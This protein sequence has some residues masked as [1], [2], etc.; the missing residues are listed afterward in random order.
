MCHQ[1]FASRVFFEWI[2][3]IDVFD[4]SSNHCSSLISLELRDRFI[5]VPWRQRQYWSCSKNSYETQLNN[6]YVNLL[7]IWSSSFSSFIC[8]LF[9]SSKHFKCWW[10]RH[11]KTKFRV[12]RSSFAC[13]F[14]C[15]L[16]CSKSWTVTFTMK[17]SD[18]MQRQ[19]I[20]HTAD[21]GWDLLII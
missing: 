7:I 3:N 12:C 2:V 11:R 17:N 16:T 21:E 14:T 18:V 15:E 9:W 4:L 19:K 8:V 20:L 1:F 13:K 10:S 6:Q 5:T